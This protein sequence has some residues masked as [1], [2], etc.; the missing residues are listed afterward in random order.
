MTLATL[1]T[2]GKVKA[3]YSD[4]YVIGDGSLGTRDRIV[5]PATG[6][7]PPALN[8]ALVLPITAGA[9]STDYALYYGA[10][11]VG[12]APSDGTRV[13][14]VYDDFTS[15][16][17]GVWLKNDAPTTSGGK[18]VL[19]GG[20]LD[21]LTTAVG[22]VPTVSAVELVATVPNPNDNPT[23]QLGG[24]FYYWFGYQRAGDF[25]QTDPWIL[26]IARGKGQVHPE[27]KSPIGCE[28]ECDGTYTDQMTTPRYYAIERDPTT[29]RF[30]IDGT[31]S[32]TTAVTNQAPYS[33][34]VR[35][36]MATSDVQIDWIRARTRV[37][38]DPTVT[39]GAEEK[40]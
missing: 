27:Q 32:A 2:E 40:L 29:T 9:T 37:A 8:F 4:L 5:D 35:N 23:A 22:L 36:F 19:R 11:S 12:A 20:H 18:L 13:F 10:P 6:P 16:I 17:S 14:S 15:G 21:A 31:V 1:L 28:A 7:A 39:F 24:T 33:V 3:D 34:M 30:V 26:W 25:D 38:P